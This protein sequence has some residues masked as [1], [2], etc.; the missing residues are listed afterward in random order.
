M[1]GF[2]DFIN[3]RR[4]GQSRASVESR[5][6]GTGAMSWPLARIPE[7]ESRKGQKPPGPR[8]AAAGAGLTEGRTP[9]RLETLKPYK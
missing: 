9:C 6:S 4:Q 3:S 7:E 2:L 5:E 1:Q 8:P